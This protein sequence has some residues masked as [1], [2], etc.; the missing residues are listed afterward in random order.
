MAAGTPDAQG[1]ARWLTPQ[2]YVAVAIFGQESFVETS[3]TSLRERERTAISNDANS[4]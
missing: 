2:A 4:A 1:A 3:S